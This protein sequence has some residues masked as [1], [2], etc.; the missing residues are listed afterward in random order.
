M[1]MTVLF[2]L[3][4]F[5][6][7]AKAEKKPFTLDDLYRIQSISDPQI[8]PDA[9]S[10]A[11]TVTKYNLYEGERN[12]DIWL[13]DAGGSN[14]RQLTRGE[15]SDRHPRWSPDG[16][17]LMFLSDRTEKTQIWLLPVDG[18]EAR[19][20]TDISTGISDPVWSPNGQTIVF[21]S[22]VFPEYGADDSLNARDL[23]SMNEGPVQAHLADRLLYRHWTAYDDGRRTHTLI[24]DVESGGIRDLTP[25]DYHAPRFSLD[26]GGFDI[27]PESGEIC[28]V[29]NHDPDPWSSTNADLWIVPLSGGSR[30]NITGEN[31]AYDG[32][33]QYSADGRYI[34]YRTQKIPGYEADRFR[35]ALYNRE[36]GEH[37]ILSES[38][39]YWV[40][41][42]R[43]SP[44][45]RSIYFT[46]QV[47]GHFPLYRVD[48][49]S[50]EI[51]KVMDVKTINQFEVSPDGEWIALTRRSVAEPAA[52]FRAGSGGSA[53]KRLEFINREVEQ[54]VDIR[55]A[56]EMWVESR[57]GRRIHMFIVKP[58]GFDASIRYPLILNVHGGPQSMWAD[59]FRGD[60]QIYPGA[61]YVVAFA[62]PTGSTGYGQELTAA[63]SGDWGG[64]VYHDIMAVAD[65]LEQLPYVDPE[66]M[67]V[68]GWSY[69]GYMMMWINGH[70]DRFKAM[71]SMMGVYDLRS[72]YGATEE[73]WFPEW[74]LKGQPW[75]SGLY[76]KWSP[77]NYV[78]NFKTPCLVIT[79]ERDYRVP[80]TQSLHFF[81]DLQKM[82][83]P[84]RLIVFKNDGHWPDYVRS[85][86]LYYN[87]HLDWFHT[88]LGGDPAPYDMGQMVRNRHFE[89]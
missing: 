79:G 88:Y 46:A 4:F 26:G 44:D 2:S 60:W 39:D 8:A 48:V 69:G 52:L 73:L 15:S 6:S 70:S 80:Y 40:E 63:I 30:R 9:K 89:P 11:F 35:L 59:A 61:G 74:D 71:A 85:M 78:E 84:S 37:R 14:L 43:W 50:A 22:K 5:V 72:K 58:H 1:R 20:L 25:G 66:R 36:T 49:E 31:R 67:G 87:A 53:L 38:F 29:S 41:R 10:V 86:P 13:V 18:G 16:A 68:M 17:T 47:K 65:R 56:E 76:E 27:S 55:P 83:V 51:R 54:Q 12:S 32:D 28:V 33:P 21:A 34:A 3:L 7:F 82:G 62:N 64:A 75:N 19:Q 23:D 24:V 81:T 77:S 45:S 57:D 42:I